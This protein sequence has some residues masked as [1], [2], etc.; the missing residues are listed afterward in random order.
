VTDAPD[1]VRTISCPGSIDIGHGVWFTF[2]PTVDGQAVFS[3]CDA[4]TAYDTVARVV[5][6]CGGMVAQIACNDDNLGCTNDCGTNRGSR[7][8]FAVTA[9]LPYHVEVGSYGNGTSCDLCLGVD[10]TISE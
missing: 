5:G 9:G 8:E 3:T 1:N 10:L 2:T 4:N 7:L 6:G